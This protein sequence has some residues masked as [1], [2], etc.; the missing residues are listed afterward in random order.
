MENSPIHEI[1]LYS[2]KVFKTL[3]DHE[4][5]KSHR[6]GDSLTLVDFLFET[7]PATPETLH[8]AE[9]FAIDLLN[10]HLRDVDIPC[11]QNNEFLILMPSTSTPGARTA[12]ERLRKLMIAE[13]QTTNGTPFR[14]TVSAGM[15]TLPLDHAISSD[16]LLQHASIALQHARTNHFTGVVAYS[17]IPK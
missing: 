11:R 12:C 6:Y 10:I 4:I 8:S 16:E 9:V 2:R 17:E 13:E 1:E 3:L 5:N 7:D 14:L 15:A